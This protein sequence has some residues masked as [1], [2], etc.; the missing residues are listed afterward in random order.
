MGKKDFSKRESRKPKKG[1][2]KMKAIS[3]ILPQPEVEVIRKPKKSREEESE[4]E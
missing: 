2:K 1:L 4:E 3:E